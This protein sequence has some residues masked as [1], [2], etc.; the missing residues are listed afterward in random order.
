MDATVATFDGGAGTG[1]GSSS[2]GGGSNH[3][4][5]KGSAKRIQLDLPSRSVER[6]NDLKD[7]TEASSYAEVVRNALR[8]YEDM[9]HKADSGKEFLLRDPSGNITPYNVFLSA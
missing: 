6:L 8:L 9:A 3:V 7:L 4:K 1:K 5:R 2:D